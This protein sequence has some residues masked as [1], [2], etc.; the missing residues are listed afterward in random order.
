MKVTLYST[1]TC[2]YCRMLKDYLSQKG[3]LFE[4]KLVD[5]DEKAREEM[6]NISGGFLGV[7]YLVVIDE[8][9][10]EFKVIGFDQGKLAVIFGEKVKE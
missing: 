9:G 3:V 10:Q 7:P 1:A 5:Q 4:E 2:P 6:I 8:K